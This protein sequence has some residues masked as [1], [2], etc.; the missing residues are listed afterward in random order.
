MLLASFRISQSLAY[1]QVQTCYTQWKF[2]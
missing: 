1:V 2:L